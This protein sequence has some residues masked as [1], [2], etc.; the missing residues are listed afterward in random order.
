MSTKLTLI[1][2][3]NAVAPCRVNQRCHDKWDQE[4][5]DF[6]RYSEKICTK[7]KS[8]VFE[9]SPAVGQ[10]LKRRSVLKW[11]LRWHDCKVPDT[12]NMCREDPLS[13]TKSEV[14]LR[15]HGYIE[16]LFELKSQAP[17]LRRKHL[18]WQLKLARERG[19]D[20]TSTEVLRI[21]KNEARRQCQ[22]NIN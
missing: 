19:D 6:M 17:M 8:C 4:M 2:E 12:R 20:V 16:H 21:I 5:G 9:F 15:L 22:Q 7:S 3:S 1:E 11:L 18:Q 13:L 10:W 14:Q